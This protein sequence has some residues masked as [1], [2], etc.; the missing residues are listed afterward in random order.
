MGWKLRGTEKGKEKERNNKKKMP[1]SLYVFGLAG[2]LAG[3]L[4][5]YKESG[6]LKIYSCFSNRSERNK[7]K[8]AY[9]SIPV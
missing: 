7:P 3:W 4:E 1:R 6:K 2:W 8:N 5:S 9:L